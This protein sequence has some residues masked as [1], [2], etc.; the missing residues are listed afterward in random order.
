[1]LYFSDV[2]H[3]GVLIT[4]GE[5]MNFKV[6]KKTL[7][8]IVSTSFLAGVVHAAAFDTAVTIISVGEKHL[9][10]SE[11]VGEKNRALWGNV[12]DVSQ[13]N[14]LDGSTVAGEAV[15]GQALSLIGYV[16]AD[17][18]AKIDINDPEA[19]KAILQQCDAIDRGE[20]VNP[21]DSTVLSYAQEAEA[22]DKEATTIF[23]KMAGKMKIDMESFK[24]ELA[25]LR[26][27]K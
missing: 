7:L 9:G 13:R 6:M 11:S 16:F 12:S 25:E 5:Y 10:A 20:E 8:V 23:R 4:R 3:F 2:H 14:P 21:A 22:T 1:M 26:S 27:A 17:S 18:G 24:K 19:A 15:T